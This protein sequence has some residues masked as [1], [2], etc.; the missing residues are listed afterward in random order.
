MKI[1]ED[2]TREFFKLDIRGSFG[3]VGDITKILKNC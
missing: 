3:I 1:F 2:K